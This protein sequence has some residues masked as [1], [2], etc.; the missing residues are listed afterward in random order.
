M[1]H[2]KYYLVLKEF[3]GDYNR[4]IYGRELLD[5]LK[6]SQK[7]IALALKE[8]EE[9]FI[10]KSRTQGTLKYYGL[11]VPLLEIK[12]IIIMTEYERK[13]RF[14]KNK[15]EIAN[16]FHAADERI[17][18]I[19]GSY[20]KGTQKKGSDIDVFII[21]NKN[22]QDYY[23]KEGELYGRDISIKYF[24]EK[25]WIKL[26]K[27]KNNL[28]VEIIRKHILFFGTERFVNILWRDYYGFD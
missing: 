26:I 19:F 2:N 17:V 20:S 14:M 18:G 21:G 5:K 11:N 3:L 12:D 13:I 23:K 9:L 8:L 28:C 1:L 6:L 4:E 25:E 22:R 10:L 16:I 15:I 27:E 7:G 24:S